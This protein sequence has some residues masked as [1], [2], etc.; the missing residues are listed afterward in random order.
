MGGSRQESK[1]IRNLGFWDLMAIAVGQ[2]V[3]A[4]IMSSTGVA[5]GMTGTGVVLAFLL[6]P[7]LTIISIFPVAIL[8]SAAPTTGGPYRYCS[9]LLGKTPGMI[10][11]FL[12]TT[13][14]AIAVSQY[15]LSFGMYFS[16]IVPSVDQHVAAMIVLTLFFAMNLVGTKSAALLNKIMTIALFG[17]L[18]LFIGYGLPKTDIPYILEPKNLFLNGPFAFVGTLAL[19]SS[20]TAGA[21][22][23]AELGGEAKDA[24]R[25]IPKAMVMSTFGV[26]ILYVLVAIVAAG[27]LPISQVADQPLTLVAGK[28]MPSVPFYLFVIGAA[29]GA[30]ATTLNATLSWITKPLL[31]AC[32]DGLLPKALG[33]VSRFGVP[34]K[35]L[36][37]FYV[38]GML[39]LAARVDIASITKFTTA[40]SLLTKLMVCAA[41]FAL[42]AKFGQI[43]KKSALH[44]T[45]G[46]SKAIAVFGGVILCVLS[47]SLFANLSPAV[48]G[49]LAVLLVAVIV[50]VKVFAKKV[51]I[52]ND[53]GVDYTS[54]D[55][56]DK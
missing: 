10:Y 40:N 3:G 23:I 37:V 21:Q 47:Y 17:G 24:G 45:A 7:F 33:S 15:A 56:K 36:S 42:A 31:V 55:K 43:L 12:H 8:S 4:G 13:A 2:I 54:A 44:I 22:F 27:I 11:L 25:N 49:F 16:S 38:I 14:F 19:L 1:L 35:L 46:Q 30:T 50:Y 51:V 26:G 34:Y 41:L 5:I 39:P 20:A 6:S 9:R 53:L 18:F 28:I 32:D 29:L 48:I 52:E